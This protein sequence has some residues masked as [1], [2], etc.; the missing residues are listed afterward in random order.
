[1][2]EQ[3]IRTI[4]LSGSLCVLGFAQRPGILGG[5]PFVHLQSS[6]N[7]V[8]STAALIRNFEGAWKNTAEPNKA[9]VE[10]RANSC[11]RAIA[12]PF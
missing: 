5:A 6:Y 7:A 9:L 4:L 11:A 2:R 3:V 1:M 8:N 12:L 10:G